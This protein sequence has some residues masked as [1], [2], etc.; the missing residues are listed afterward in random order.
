MVRHLEPTVKDRLRAWALPVVVAVMATATAFL[1]QTLLR[2]VWQ[3]RTLPERVMEWLLLF[4]PLDL[5]ERGLARFGADAKQ[6]ALTSTAVGMAVL[7]IVI[8]ALALRANWN[9]WRLLAVGFGLWLFA[10]L[11]VMPIT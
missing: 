5:F 10:M 8:G 1:L 4:V 7:L 2:N 9:S 6:L 3:I 11:V